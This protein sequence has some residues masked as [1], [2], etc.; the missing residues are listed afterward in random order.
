MVNKY[1]IF[2]IEIHKKLWMEAESFFI[3]LTGIVLGL[4][5]IN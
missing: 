2:G 3:P 4:Y 5:N 1:D